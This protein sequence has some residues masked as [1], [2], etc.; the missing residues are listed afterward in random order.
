[1][2][3]IR[4][5]VMLLM[6]SA[7]KAGKSRTA[8]LKDMKA[9]GTTYLGRQ[10]KADWATLTEF[11]KKTGALSRLRKD[12]FPREASTVVTDW[13]TEGEYMYII[14]V[15][16]RLSPD[17][18]ITERFVDIVTDEPMTG[19][20]MIQAAT[21]KWVEWEYEEIVEEIIPWTAVRSTI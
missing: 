2:S 3:V 18:P 20:M 9:A 1:M 14:K 17:A 7:I 6:R 21:Q 5:D 10:M 12:V 15:K 8:F 13:D 4:K 11:H 19:E 16:T